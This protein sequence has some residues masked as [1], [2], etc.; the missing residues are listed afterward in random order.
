[1]SRTAQV[2]SPHTRTAVEFKMRV[3]VRSTNID[4]VVNRLV[5]RE[6]SRCRSMKQQYSLPHILQ[7]DRST[8]WRPTTGKNHGIDIV[9]VVDDFF[10][11]FL[12]K[13]LHHHRTLS[14][15]SASEGGG[16]GETPSA[17]FDGT[18]ATSDM[19]P[20][21]ALGNTVDFSV[22]LQTKARIQVIH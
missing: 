3:R 15:S 5:R 16:H 20:V 4:P 21:P 10:D 8:K 19:H 11:E 6:S 14:P 17:V 22:R 1:M 2:Y 7:R 13:F 9:N 12:G 18:E